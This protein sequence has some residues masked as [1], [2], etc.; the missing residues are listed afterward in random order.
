MTS[1]PSG[2][3]SKSGSLILTCI[4]KSPASKNSPS[5]ISPVMPEACTGKMDL[6]SGSE[7]VDGSKS[8]GMPNGTGYTV[9]SRLTVPVLA[10]S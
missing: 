1:S 2:E 4:V 9:L 7:A 10:N 3:M 6:P 8:S 5:P